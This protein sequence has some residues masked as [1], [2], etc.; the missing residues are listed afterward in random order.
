MTDMF[1]NGSS[2]GGDAFA[3]FCGDLGPF[4]DSNLTWYTTNPDVTQCFQNTVL[5]WVPCGWLVLVAPFYMY[6]MS[7]VRVF[8]VLPTFNVDDSVVVTPVSGT[9]NA[10]VSGSRNASTSR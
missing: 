6:Y 2:G 4:W 5:L 8:S 9:A 10:S 3:R 1:T 7:K